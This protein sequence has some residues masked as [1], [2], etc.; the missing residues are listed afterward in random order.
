[1]EAQATSNARGAQNAPAYNRAPVVAPTIRGRHRAG[2]GPGRAGGVSGETRTCSATTRGSGCCSAGWCTVS[3]PHV[4]RRAGGR[5]GGGGRAAAHRSVLG[6]YLWSEQ[7]SDVEAEEQRR[8]E[9]AQVASQFAVD[10]N[11]YSAADIDTYAD[12]VS[13]QLT[14]DFS[15]RSTTPSR[16]WSTRCGRPRSSPR[17]PCCAPASRRRRRLRPGARGRRRDRRLGPADPRPALS[18]GGRAGACRRRWLVDDFTP[19]A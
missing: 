9:V 7:I 11:T 12:R 1:M 8:D 6:G 16:V 3:P 15:G 19:V 4:R 2:P 10:V 5:D 18:L 17:A 14:E 13:A